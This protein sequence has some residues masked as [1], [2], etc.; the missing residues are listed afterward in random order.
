MSYYIN[1]TMSMGSDPFVRAT[2]AGDH[3]SITLPTL[4]A[5]RLVWIPNAPRSGR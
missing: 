1:N 2:R 3:L 4:D 5:Y